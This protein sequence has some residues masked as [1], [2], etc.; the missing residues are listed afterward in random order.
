[1][2]LPR[3]SGISWRVQCRRMGPSTLE[4]RIAEG[5]A[6]GAGPSTLEL[7]IEEGSMPQ[8]GTFHAGGPNRGGSGTRSGTFHAEAAYRGRFNAAGWDLPRWS[9]I[10]RKVHYH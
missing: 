8:D 1:M 3:W 6:H 7:H 9:C 4:A 10:S 5:P 2:D